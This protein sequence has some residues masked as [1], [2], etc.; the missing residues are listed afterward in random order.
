M[1]SAV[2]FQFQ[3]ARVVFDSSGR[4]GMCCDDAGSDHRL[5]HYYGDRFDSRANLYDW[6]YYMCLKEV[7]ISIIHI[8]QYKRWRHFGQ[9]FEL[10]YVRV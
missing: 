3:T 10:R 1:C 6:D 2:G 4:C 7:G 5:R 9:A 8:I